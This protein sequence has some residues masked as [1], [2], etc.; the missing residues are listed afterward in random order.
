MPH[1]SW[2]HHENRALFKRGLKRCSKCTKVKALEE[3]HKANPKLYKTG[4]KSACK[5][6]L[7]TRSPMPERQSDARRKAVA[8]NKRLV[9]RGKKRCAKCRRVR[10]LG[11][12]WKNGCGIGGRKPI[13][14]RCDRRRVAVWSHRALV[15]ARMEA[16]ARYG[17][18]CACCGESRYEF[19]AI[20]HR[21]GG[22][23]RHRL[24]G[25]FTPGNGFIKW[26]KRNGWPKG[27]RVLCHNC[28]SA[29]GYYGY[30][31]HKRTGRPVRDKMLVLKEK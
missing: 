17:G 12:F 10:P 29:L 19:L 23:S 5:I 1:A 21:R 16:I 20:D 8:E 28:N 27:F 25:Q 18:K 22:G 4:R 9:R 6:C 2:I 7:G 13:C 31:P 26:L 11:E 15:K 24:S 14:V 30:C 3:F